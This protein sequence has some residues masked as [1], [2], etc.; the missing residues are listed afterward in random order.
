MFLEL[1]ASFV[2]GLGAA[3]VMLALNL[4][5]GRRLPRWL[6][7]VA[8]GVAMIGFAVWSEYSWAT[9]TAGGLP[10]GVVEITRVPESRPWKPW[11]YLAPQA[12]RL[13]AADVA[14]AARR[15]DAPD[16][17]LV[18]LYFF[19]RWQPAQ[20]APVLVDCTAPARADVTDAALA[21]PA[22]ASWRALSPDDPLVRTVCD[23]GAS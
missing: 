1:I 15:Q 22:A 16:T 6:M 20:S 3:G 19:A 8:G 17:R 23:D 12:T 9:R 2:A 13:M 5:T 14:G 4:A 10:Q 18:T 7:P 11:T 21:D